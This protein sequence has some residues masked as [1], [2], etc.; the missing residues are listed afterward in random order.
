MQDAFGAPEY[1]VDFCMF[2]TAPVKS[3]C[4]LSGLK[5]H[6]FNG[7]KKSSQIKGKQINETWWECDRLRVQELSK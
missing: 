3:D 6:T 7:E 2:L 1:E 5:Q 4:K